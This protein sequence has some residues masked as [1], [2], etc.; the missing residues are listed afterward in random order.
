MMKAKLGVQLYSLRDYIKD[1]KSLGSA[2]K[3]IT[4]IGYSAVELACIESMYPPDVANVLH[5]SGLDIAACHIGW[6]RYQ[7]ELDQVIRELKMYNCKHAVI[8]GVFTKEYRSFEGLMRF[9]K[10]V[11]EVSSKLS[12]EGI[13]LSYHNHN[14][15]M[16]KYDGKTWLELLYQNTSSD[17]LK[18]E[19]D[20]YWIQAGGGSPVSWIRKLKGRQILIHY[21]D[22]V[23]TQDKLNDEA[24]AVRLSAGVGA[25]QRVTEIGNGNLDFGEILH[26]A[27]EAGVEYYIVEQDESFDLT[28]W[29]SVQKSYEN[30]S[31]LL[32]EGL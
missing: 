2:L 10:E 16:C 3:K 8:P 7:E 11:T 30:L 12:E 4:D 5:E 22:F 15:E 27:A 24:L 9:V 25:E 28:A 13:D 21:K 6:K 29:Q 32:S 1:I 31:K 26:A 19:L 14:H 23:V 20:V 18:A 17:V